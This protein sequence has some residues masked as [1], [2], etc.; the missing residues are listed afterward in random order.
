MTDDRMVFVRR[1]IFVLPATLVAA[2]LLTS[3]GFV[4]RHFGHKDAEY[5][6]STQEHPLE[7]PPDLDTPST[8]GALIV[9]SVS[10]T[11]RTSSTPSATLPATASDPSTIPPSTTIPSGVQI[12]GDGLQV[13]DSVENTWTRVGLA[14][15]RSGVATLLSRDEVGRAYAVETTG[16]TTAKA[17]WWKRAVTLGLAGSKVTAKV[18]LTVRVSGDGAGSRVTVEGAADDASREA[19]RSLLATLRQRMS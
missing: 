9:P 19:A 6:K 13:A 1:N 7:V 8:S 2:S 10:A 18:Q 11:A 15:E 3:C 14:L 5:R 4:H 16:Q 17:S 12:G